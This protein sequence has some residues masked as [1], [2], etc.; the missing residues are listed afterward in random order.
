LTSHFFTAMKTRSLP[1]INNRTIDTLAMAKRT[2]KGLG[3]YKLGDLAEYFELAAC[4]SLL[5]KYNRHRG[6]GDCYMTHELYQKLLNY[7]LTR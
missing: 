7:D 5:P 1:P 6:L 4:A 3:S 2:C